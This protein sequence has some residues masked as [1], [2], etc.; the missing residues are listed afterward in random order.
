MTGFW[1]GFFAAWAVIA[2]VDTVISLALIGK[3]VEKDWTDPA[4][5]FGMMVV[6]MLITWYLVVFA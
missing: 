4:F 5:S 3:T 2:G 1:V 6:A